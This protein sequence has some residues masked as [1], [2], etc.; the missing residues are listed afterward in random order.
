MPLAATPWFDD[1]RRD[2]VHRDRRRIEPAQRGANERIRIN[3]VNSG[4]EDTV[5]IGAKLSER[6]VQ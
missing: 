4:A 5:Q 6:E 1:F 3:R 2:D